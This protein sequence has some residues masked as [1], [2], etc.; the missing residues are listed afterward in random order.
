MQ[1]K[2]LPSSFCGAHLSYQGNND[3]SDIHEDT[4]RRNTA[5]A[6][7]SKLLLV[8]SSFEDSELMK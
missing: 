3:A 8:P 4:N 5:S 7:Q 6:H 1:R 2:R